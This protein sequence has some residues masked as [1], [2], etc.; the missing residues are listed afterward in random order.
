MKKL[1]LIRLALINLLLV[2]CFI[3]PYL[4]GPSNDIVTAVSLY[5]QS[6]GFLGLI[7]LPIGLIWITF[8]L[9]KLRSNDLK[10]SKISFWLAIIATLL[11]TLIGVLMTVVIIAQFSVFGGIMGSL[12]LIYALIKSVKGIINLRLQPSIRFNVV[13]VYLFIIPLV[14]LGARFYMEPSLSTYSRNTAIGQGESLIALIE[15]YKNKQGYYP[16]RLSDL[17]TSPRTHVM[18]IQPFR[19]NTTG[20]DFHLSFS[21]W[22]QFGIVEEIVLYDRKT[23]EDVNQAYNYYFD[24]HRV[25]GAFASYNTHHTHWRYYLCD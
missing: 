11:I 9:L 17:G 24:Q 23:A 8:E 25:K 2:V 5:A 1:H 16:S 6:P 15:E 10:Y 22:V 19:Y 7:V 14:S 20:N 3:L 12:I 21:Q 18:G 4:P 13:P